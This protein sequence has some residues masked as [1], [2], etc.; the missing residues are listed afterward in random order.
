MEQRVEWLLGF[1]QPMFMTNSNSCACRFALSDQSIVFVSTLPTHPTPP[2]LLNI[3][4][5]NRKRYEN[6]TIIVL[7]SLLTLCNCNNTV[8]AYLAMA[9]SPCYLYSKYIDWIGLFIDSYV[10]ESRK[11]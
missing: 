5:V 7:K 2:S 9:P 3:L 6:F 11:Y 4:F 10:E 1:P 8:F